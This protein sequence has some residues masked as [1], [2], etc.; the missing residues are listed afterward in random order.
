MGM[1][2]LKTKRERTG[3]ISETKEAFLK[4]DEVNKTKR[5]LTK[6]TIGSGKLYVN[7]ETI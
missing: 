1:F 7:F 3:C 4:G 6:G 2:H 5:E